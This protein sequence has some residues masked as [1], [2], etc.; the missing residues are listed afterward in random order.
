[1]L[2]ATDYTHYYPT[3]KNRIT[4]TDTKGKTNYT[5]END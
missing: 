2:T 3:F 5:Y 1:M 4:L